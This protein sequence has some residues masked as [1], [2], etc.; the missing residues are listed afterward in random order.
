METSDPFTN[1]RIN[2]KEGYGIADYKDISTGITNNQP[3]YITVARLDQGVF[4]PGE[5]T[6]YAIEFEPKNEIPTSGS[7]VIKWPEQITVVPGESYCQVTT[8]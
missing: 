7:V 8:T 6:D 1:I 4:L 5:K 3:D 2:D